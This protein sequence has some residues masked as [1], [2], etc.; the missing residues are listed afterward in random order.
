MY[1]SKS[2]EAGDCGCALMPRA[3]IRG[4]NRLKSTV[5]CCVWRVIESG[6]GMGGVWEVFLRLK[7]EPHG[8]LD[9]FT[10]R[11]RCHPDGL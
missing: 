2:G 4:M 1:C 10:I 6:Y 11:L 5:L 3:P 7:G 8:M 9:P